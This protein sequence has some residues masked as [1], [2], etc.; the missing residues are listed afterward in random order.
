MFGGYGGMYGGD[1]P[2]AAAMPDSTGHLVASHAHHHDIT[3]LHTTTGM[4]ATPQQTAATATSDDDEENGDDDNDGIDDGD[5]VP[6]IPAAVPVRQTPQVGRGRPRKKPLDDAAAAAAGGGKKVKGEKGQRSGRK[7]SGAPPRPRTAF[8]FW[9]QEQRPLLRQE[10]PDIPFL[11][12]AKVLAEKWKTVSKENKVKWQ[13]LCEED[14]LRYEREMS[15]FKTMND[16]AAGTSA[17]G[18]GDISLT[19]GSPTKGSNTI[20]IKRKRKIGVGVR[21][22][23]TPY[24]YYAMDVWN[25]VQAEHPDKKGAE[26]GQIMLESWNGLSETD[27]APFQRLADLD[28][29]RY[30]EEQKADPTTFP[31]RR[32]RIRSSAAGRRLVKPLTGFMYYANATREQLVA[33]ARDEGHEIPP[34]M[35]GTVLTDKWNSLG[36][37]EKAPFME[38]YHKDKARYNREIGEQRARQAA[39]ENL[40]EQQRKEQK[41]ATKAA[42]AK[43]AA[44]AARAAAGGAATADDDDDNA[45]NA[46]ADDDDDANADGDGSDEDS[47]AHHHHPAATQSHSIG[48]ASY[49]HG[50]THSGLKLTF[51][52]GGAGVS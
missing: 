31:D 11:E 34:T 17:T 35:I 20:I 42:A 1:D 8:V 41:A 7:K 50:H 46:A 43:S 23:L 21:T 25:K 10:Q 49:H 40:K 22:P 52:A 6:T 33:T 51:R 9:S 29:I 26:L 44:A 45:S 38:L 37:D 30:D 2:F 27:R 16:G 13:Q 47:S 32:L 18:G 3:G 15:E 48:A 28:K 19:A 24:T 5:S 4:G 14:K 39:A 12:L 36:G